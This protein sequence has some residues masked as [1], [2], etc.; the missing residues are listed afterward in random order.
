MVWLAVNE[1]WNLAGFGVGALAGF[2]TVLGLK[3]GMFL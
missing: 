1:A 3:S 2:A